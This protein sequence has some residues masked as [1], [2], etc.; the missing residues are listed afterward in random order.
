[1]L[2]QLWMEEHLFHRLGYLNCGMTDLECIEKHEKRVEGYE[3]PDGTEAY[4][5]HLRSLTANKIEWTFRW[6]SVSEV[7]YISVEVC[8]LLLM[9]LKSIQPYA[10]HQVLHQLGRYQTIP[11]D[12]DLS[13]H[14]IE[15]EPKAAFLEERVRQIWHRCKFL[16]TR[17]QVRDL[18]KGEVEPDYT[19]WYGKRSRVHHEPERPAKKPHV[20]QFTDEAQA[21]WDWLTKENEPP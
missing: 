17:T 21:Q 20:Q 10:P 19:A 14:V 9:G 8:F 18:S 5:A 2:L 3:F 1:M 7:V 12:E 11:H 6:L 16:E 15:L 4:H 13:R